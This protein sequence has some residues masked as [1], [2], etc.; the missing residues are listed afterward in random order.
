MDPFIGQISMFGFDWAPRG[1]AR[2]DGQLLPIAQYQSLFALI[3]TIYGG[4]GR[5]TFALPGLRG[6]VGVHSGQGAGLNSR[7]IGQKTGHQTTIL[8]TNN[9][10]AHSHTAVVGG[11]VKMP[12]SDG[13]PNTDAIAGAYL[14]NQSTDF[15][16]DTA[17]TGE[18][19]GALSNQI[20]VTV[21]NTGSATDFNNMQPFQVINYCIAL[22]GVFPSR[23]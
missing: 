23:N 8:N 14:T 2:C 5:T 4:D 20:T 12:V 10:P 7:P 11:D 22:V 18:F 19:A 21:A 3:G 1:W 6:R 17:S 16:H 13:D 9:M 15:Y